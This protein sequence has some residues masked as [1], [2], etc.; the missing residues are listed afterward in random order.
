MPKS[1]MK[2]TIYMFDLP[3]TKIITMKSRNYNKLK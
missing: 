2:V 3:T 1:N